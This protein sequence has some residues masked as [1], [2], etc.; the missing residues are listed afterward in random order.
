MSDPGSRPPEVRVDWS[1]TTFEGARREQLRRWSELSLRQVIT[2]LEEMEE[3]NR[4]FN[5]PLPDA[6]SR[7]GA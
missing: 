3:L 5:S 1:L 4:R 2:A 7:G 6:K